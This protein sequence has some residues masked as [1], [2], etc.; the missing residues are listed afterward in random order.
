M[1]DLSSLLLHEN[2]TQPSKRKQNITGI[3]SLPR[4]KTMKI[5]KS[6]TPIAHILLRMTVE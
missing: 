2:C 4:K 5:N 3:N 1:K 6:I